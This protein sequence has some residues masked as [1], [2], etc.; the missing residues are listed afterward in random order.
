[1][2]N[3]SQYIVSIALRFFFLVLALRD[4]GRYNEI[5]ILLTA[6]LLVVLAKMAVAQ[7]YPPELGDLKVTAPFDFV[8]ERHVLSRGNYVLR[9]DEA[10]N[11]VQ[12]CEDGI[13]CESLRPSLRH[14]KPW[15]N[16]NWSLAALKEDVLCV[17]SGSRRA[18]DSSCLTLPCNQKLDGQVRILRRCTWTPSPCASIT[19]R[20]YLPLGIEGGST[21]TAPGT[22]KL[23]PDPCFTKE[24]V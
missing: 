18:L 2:S 6:N 4:E 22:W 7:I 15:L 5:S 9:W 17:R 21:G 8:A 20:G 19:A 3:Q 14:H 1:M 10:S 13:I 11:R 16:P 24:T 12:I 23:T